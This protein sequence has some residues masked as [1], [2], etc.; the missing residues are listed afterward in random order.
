MQGDVHRGKEGLGSHGLHFEAMTTSLSVLRASLNY[1]ERGKNRQERRALKSTSRE[2]TRVKRGKVWINGEMKGAGKRENPEKTRRLAGIARHDSRLRISESDPAGNRTRFALLGDYIRKWHFNLGATVA[3]RLACSP[4][5]KANLFLSPGRFTPD[6]R[7]CES[8]VTMPLASGFSPGVSHFSRPC[9][10]TLLH[11]H[12]TSPSALKRLRIIA[13]LEGGGVIAILSTFRRVSLLPPSITFDEEKLRR[14]FKIQSSAL[15]KIN[16]V[17]QKQS[18]DTH[19]TPYDQVK[20]CR[21]RKINIKASERVN[22]STVLQ[23]SKLGQYH[24]RGPASQPCWKSHLG[25]DPSLWILRSWWELALH[26]AIHLQFPPHLPNPTPSTPPCEPHRVTY[27]AAR[28]VRK[29]MPRLTEAKA[30]ML[31][32][33]DSSRRLLTTAGHTHLHVFLVR[34]PDDKDTVSSVTPISGELFNIF[35]PVYW[36]VEGVSCN[37]L[38][39]VYKREQQSHEMMRAYPLVDWPCETLERDLRLIGYCVIRVLPHW[40]RIRLTSELPRADLLNGAPK[41]L[42]S[43]VTRKFSPLPDVPAETA[44]S[45]FYGFTQK[46]R[47]QSINSHRRKN[48]YVEENDKAEGTSMRVSSSQTKWSGE[49][50]AAL[51]REVRREWSNARKS[52]AVWKREMPE[53]KNPPDQRNRP[54]RLSRANLCLGVPSAKA[55]DARGPPLTAC[56]QRKANT[57]LGVCSWLPCLGSERCWFNRAGRVGTRWGEDWRKS[58]ASMKVEDK[59]AALLVPLRAGLEVGG[60]QLANTSPF[61]KSFATTSPK[62]R[63]SGCELSEAMTAVYGLRRLISAADICLAEWS[64]LSPPPPCPQGILVRKESFYPR[65]CTPYSLEHIF[66]LKDLCPVH[67]GRYTQAFDPT[68]RS[69]KHSST[70]K[71]TLCACVGIALNLRTMPDVYTRTMPGPHR[72][73]QTLNTSSTSKPG[74]HIENNVRCLLQHLHQRC[75]PP[76]QAVRVRV[77]GVVTPGFSYVADDVDGRR[78]FSGI[79]HFPFSFIPALLHKHLASSSSAF[80]TSILTAAIITSLT[81]FRQISEK[82]PACLHRSPPFLP[83]KRGSY[84][85]HIGTRYNCAIAAT[86]RALN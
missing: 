48:M 59:Y 57:F 19:K 15:V 4:P 46:P 65:P 51:E 67:G 40:L 62:T 68:L 3:E 55:R 25:F 21:E 83:E 32:E 8:H 14:S 60:L 54:S 20:R 69:T 56:V 47:E 82:G 42:L 23:P 45:R 80:K 27:L 44:Y 63:L 76:T 24:V 9:I 17:S 7:K 5:T 18:S 30:F 28:G 38:S 84:K 53:S 2:P 11:T 85:G 61:T 13:N 43:D 71:V 34:R 33:A 16:R 49:I 6:F 36:P 70:A 22:P 39:R 58:G 31:S 37:C 81:P 26:S 73:R 75:S 41:I 66:G 86:R 52:R 72:E 74:I 35:G 12:F 64:T 77:T 10:L 50:G 79:S 78:V 1:E 29:G